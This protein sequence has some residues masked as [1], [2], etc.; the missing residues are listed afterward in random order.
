MALFIRITLTDLQFTD[1]AKFVFIIWIPVGPLKFE[2]KMG[3]SVT[4]KSL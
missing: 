2:L 4:L 1:K 3:L